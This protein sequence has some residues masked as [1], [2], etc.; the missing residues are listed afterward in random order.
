MQRKHLLLAAFA[1]F[2][3]QAPQQAKAYGLINCSESTMAISAIQNA[4][5]TAQKVRSIG[6]VPSVG[7]LSLNVPHF[8]NCTDFSQYQIFVQRNAGGVSALRNALRSNPVTRQ[9][10]QSRGIPIGLIAAVRVSSNGSLRVYVLNPPA[11]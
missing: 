5:R 7:V 8:A 9:A 6:S 3:M 11:R 2:L 4:S 1:A 10:L